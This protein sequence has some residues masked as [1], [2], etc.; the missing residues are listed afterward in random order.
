MW[1]GENQIRRGW[2]DVVGVAQAGARKE[3]FGKL[4]RLP[5]VA[6]V[7]INGP[8]AQACGRGQAGFLTRPDL[9]AR[10]AFDEAKCSADVGLIRLAC[11][12]T[13]A[14]SRLAFFICIA[15]NVECI[16][17]RSQGDGICLLGLPMQARD[18]GLRSRAI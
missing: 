6:V 2:W 15:I 16:C 18:E 8:R 3:A 9:L 1:T 5:V 12:M 7:G 14:S 17:E 4:R 13:S 10:V 11:D